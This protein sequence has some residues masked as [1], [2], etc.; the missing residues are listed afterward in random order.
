MVLEHGCQSKKNL[1]DDKKKLETI[2]TSLPS[3]VQGMSLYVFRQTKHS[4]LLISD[5]HYLAHNWH[6]SCSFEP[7]IGEVLL[8]YWE[9]HYPSHASTR[10]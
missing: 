6:M 9:R 1:E 2:H 5:V 8:H 7:R 10:I 4:E 3:K